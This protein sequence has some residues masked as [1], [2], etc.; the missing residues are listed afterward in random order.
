MRSLFNPYIFLVF[1]KQTW[2]ILYLAHQILLF[3]WNLAQ[4][5]F[6]E[7][8]YFIRFECFG[9]SVKNCYFSQNLY[10]KLLDN[11]LKLCFLVLTVKIERDLRIKIFGEHLFTFFYLFKAIYFT[12]IVFKVLEVLQH[13]NELYSFKGV[14]FQEFVELVA[15]RLLGS[16]F[17]KLHGEICLAFHNLDLISEVFHCFLRG[18]KTL[19]KYVYPFDFLFHHD[20]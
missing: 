13:L 4:K 7:C 14:F 3:K 15:E 12:V 20:S 11:C 18:L 2:K 1:F 10:L 19:L 6:H 9:T 17:L 5:L 8:S 16:S